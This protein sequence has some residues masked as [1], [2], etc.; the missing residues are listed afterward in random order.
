MLEKEIEKFEKYVN[1]YNMEDENIL[2]K[3]MHSFRVMKYS[4]EIAKGINLN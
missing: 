2:R 4:I 3:Y 1:N